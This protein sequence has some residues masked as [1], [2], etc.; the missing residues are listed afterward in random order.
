[1]L[2]AQRADTAADWLLRKE[3]NSLHTGQWLA[4]TY[5]AISCSSKAI[6]S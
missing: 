1:M 3:R 2:C 4:L 6:S 5:W